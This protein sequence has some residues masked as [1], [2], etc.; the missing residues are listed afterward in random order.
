MLLMAHA[1][2]LGAVWLSELKETS[3]TRDTGQEF[4]EKYGL[5]DHIEVHFHIALGWTAIGSIKSAR[6]DLADLVIRR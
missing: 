6:P 5:P 3:K 2:G 1:L 4:K